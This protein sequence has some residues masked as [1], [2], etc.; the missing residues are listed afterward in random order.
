MEIAAA[1]RVRWIG[2][3]TFQNNLIGLDTG[4]GFGHGREQRFGVRVLGV[5]EQLIGQAV[6]DQ[7]AHIHHRHPIANVFHDAQVV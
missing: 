1:R 5:Q 3:V 4:I 7:L 6:F 2:D